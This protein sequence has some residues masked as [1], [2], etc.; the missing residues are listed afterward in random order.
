M[1]TT[2][3]PT[4][5]LSTDRVTV[6]V[7]ARFWWDHVDRDC[8]NHS[9]DASEYLVR[10]TKVDTTGGKVTSR[11]TPLL[12]LSLHPYDVCDLLSDADYYADPYTA[13]EMGDLG[14]ASSARAIAR[15]VRE[16]F[17][18]EQL[19]AWSK[20]WADWQRDEVRSHV[21][22]LVIPAPSDAERL[23]RIFGAEWVELDDELR[24]AVE[25]D[26]AAADGDA[27]QSYSWNI[28][29][30]NLRR[31]AECVRRNPPVG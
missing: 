23:A 21:A 8:V 27:R 17:P 13:R 14:L 11:R 31:Y 25:A 5:P 2:P 30:G 3:T 4:T 10:T 16:A 9:G 18:A 26:W 28:G 29:A 24:Q 15:R 19:Q 6:V 20:A 12:T 22:A 1:T 7:P